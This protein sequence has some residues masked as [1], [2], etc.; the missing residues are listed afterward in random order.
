MLTPTWSRDRGASA[1]EFA[2]VV[3]F[4]VMLLFG[5]I[6]VGLMYDHKQDLEAAAREG[7]RLAT[8]P[9]VT[10]DQV[11]TAV[12]L[13]LDPEIDAAITV[14]PDVERPCDGRPGERVA[15]AVGTTARLDILFV[16]SRNVTITGG[17]DFRCAPP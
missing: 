1:V 11:V 7:A 3:P 13:T 10:V 14:E 5:M 17:A 15:V 9:A 8:N 2:L 16:G 6:Q 4:L 12:E